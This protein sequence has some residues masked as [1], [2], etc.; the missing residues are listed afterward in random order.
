MIP[1]VWEQASLASRIA[2]DDLRK[3]VA[4]VISD[5][6][7]LPL[8]RS[9]GAR[10]IQTAGGPTAV[11]SSVGCIADRADFADAWSSLRT[12]IRRDPLLERV[13]PG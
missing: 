5:E 13:C 9:T 1:A 8:V 3:T 4:N 10:S 6:D 12:G 11:P 2:L 7:D